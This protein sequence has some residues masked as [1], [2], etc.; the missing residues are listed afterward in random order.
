M[1]HI[2]D[3]GQN[4]FRRSDPV[5]MLGQNG[6]KIHPMT[7]NANFLLKYHCTYVMM[8]NNFGVLSFSW[9]LIRSSQSF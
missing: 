4:G 6:L 3:T 5:R 7:C 2:F 9:V 1:V 8:T